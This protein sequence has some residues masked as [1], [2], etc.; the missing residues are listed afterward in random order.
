ML[1]K[2]YC[3]TAATPLFHDVGVPGFNL[4]HLQQ[5]LLQECTINT[6]IRVLGLSLA[7]L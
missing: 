1:G 3:T 2:L 6:H 4:V 7:H 5:R